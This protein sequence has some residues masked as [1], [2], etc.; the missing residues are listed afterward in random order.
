MTITKREILFSI[1]II[2]VFIFLGIF[3]ADGIE[4]G[5]LEEAEKY[6]KALKVEDAKMFE[7]NRKTN[8]GDTLAYGKAKF[9]DTVTFPEINGEYGVIVKHE[10]QY[11]KHIDYVTKEDD[12]GNTYTEEVITYSWDSHGRKTLSGKKVNFLDQEF[13]S[14]IFELGSGSTI[15]LK[16]Y[17][18][19]QYADKVHFNYLYQ[20]SST[21]EN[22]GDL[23]WRY[24]VVP[25]EFMGSLFL[26]FNDEDISDKNSDFYYEQTIEQVVEAKENAGTTSRI[27]FWILWILFMVFI[28]WFFYYMDNHWLE[29]RKR[30]M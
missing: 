18:K 6:Y 21:W 7:Y 23:R 12:E 9:L 14:E 25:V 5:H 30:R 22:V 10:E 20:H 4:Q 16:R 27:I 29:D 28:V 26:T 2:L 13:N 17:I 19:K 3:I 24:S 15:E 1:I 11:T 8:G